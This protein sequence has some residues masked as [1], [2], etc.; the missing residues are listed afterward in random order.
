MFLGRSFAA[1]GK[2]LAQLVEMELGGDEVDRG[3][4]RC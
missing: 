4:N 3:I 1:V 2:A